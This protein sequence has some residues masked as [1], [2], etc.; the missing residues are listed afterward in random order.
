MLL[1]S[2]DN[3][4]L[5]ALADEMGTSAAGV[6]RILIRREAKRLRVQPKKGDDSGD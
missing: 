5:A 6:V 2:A 3:E 4:A 1:T